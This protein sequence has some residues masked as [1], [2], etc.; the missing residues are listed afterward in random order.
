MFNMKKQNFI[1][2]NCY[3]YIITYFKYENTIILLCFIYY[4]PY[5]IL[6]NCSRLV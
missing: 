2:N 3:N 5:I 1:P 4:N 6:N